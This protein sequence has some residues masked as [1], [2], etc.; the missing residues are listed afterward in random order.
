MYLV[1]SK[2]KMSI[3]SIIES[4]IKLIKAIN[5]VMIITGKDIISTHITILVTMYIFQ[6]LPILEITTKYQ[7]LLLADHYKVIFLLGIFKSRNK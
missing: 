7:I 2:S 6:K 4:I 3:F 1:V 5:D